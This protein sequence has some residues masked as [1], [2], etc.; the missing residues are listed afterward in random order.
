MSYFREDILRKQI[1]V[2]TAI[3]C[4]GTLALGL[5]SYQAKAQEPL[6]PPTLDVKWSAPG[7]ANPESVMLSA[8]GTFL[9]VSNV[10]G[11]ASEHDGNG[12][13]SKL[14]KDGTMITEKWA[15]GLD[16][17][18]GMALNGDKLYVSDINHLVEIDAKS[19]E[20]LG[21][22]HALDARFLNDVA[23]V[24]GLGVLVSGSGT[25]SIYL[26]DG[27]A[28]SVWLEGDFLKGIN[29]LHVDGDRLLIVTMSAGELLSLDI[30]S[31]E[32]T[33]IA[34]GMTRADGIKILPD[35]SYFMSSWPGRLFHVSKDGTITLLQDTREQKLN[36]N[37]FE[38]EGDTAYMANFGSGTVQAIKL[39]QG[40]IPK[41]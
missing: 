17:P 14:A 22:F 10:N 39:T 31:K 38:L 18:K 33:I 37:D 8:D 36:M 9:Y 35:G 20:V 27:E 15:S 2:L 7:F 24:P 19:G 6:A 16:A 29:G 30:K 41:P 28:M 1:S 4:A 25:Q 5:Q 21:A 13:I 34:S 26:Y 3:M 40:K 23:Y 12:F 11:Q 32:F